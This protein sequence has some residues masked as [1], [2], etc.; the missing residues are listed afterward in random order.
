MQP[1]ILASMF[2][3]HA[4]EISHV[5]E[6]C[7]DVLANFLCFSNLIAG[8]LNE[9]CVGVW[10][11]L[12]LQC[13]FSL[14]DLSKNALCTV[15]PSSS[16]MTRRNLSSSSIHAH[17][18]ILPSELNLDLGRMLNH[19]ANPIFLYYSP[20]RSLAHMFEVLGCLHRLC[21]LIRTL[22]LTRRCF[23]RSG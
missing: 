20:I 10:K 14:N 1:G 2:Y 15:L 22:R 17:F 3:G 9:C 5:V 16:R 6:I 19:P 7:I 8:E 18:L 21:S 11:V 23:S 12:D 4:H 13:C